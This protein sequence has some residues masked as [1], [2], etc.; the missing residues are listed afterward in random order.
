MLRTPLITLTAAVS[1]AAFGCNN[2]RDVTDSL[3]ESNTETGPE[4]T[5]GLSDP[6]P[7]PATIALS[8]PAFR[9]G[10]ALPTRFT[11]DGRDVSPPLS[12]TDV[13]EGARSLVLVVSDP[14]APRG[15]FSHWVVFNL[16]PDLNE[17]QE[18]IGPGGSIGSVAGASDTNPTQGTN[19]FNNAGYN[20]PCPPQGSAHHYV[21]QIYALDTVLALD[22]SANREQILEALEGHVLAEG[23]LTAVFSREQAS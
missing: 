1:L 19:G 14:D 15:T 2:N 10:G 8:S 4:M 20:G 6:A 23:R 7:T 3:I 18:G 16:P 11:C 5:A 21:F 12:W 9:D 13:P 17:L 22:E